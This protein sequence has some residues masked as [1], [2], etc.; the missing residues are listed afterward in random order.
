MLCVSQGSDL[1]YDKCWKPHT[2]KIISRSGN[3]YTTKNIKYKLKH[4]RNLLWFDTSYP[5]THAHHPKGGTC[6]VDFGQHLKS[7]HL[8]IINL[9]WEPQ[10][11]YI[12]LRKS[13]LQAKAHLPIKLQTANPFMT[14]LPKSL[15]PSS[16]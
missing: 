11:S 7:V 15:H 2:K 5:T 13:S 6:N 8:L 10:L 4:I 14:Q 9:W 3:R 12:A 1:N 16:T